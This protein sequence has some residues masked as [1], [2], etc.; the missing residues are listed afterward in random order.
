MNDILDE[1]YW[2][3]YHPSPQANLHK[4]I[5]SAHWQLIERLDKQERKLILRIYRYQRHDC[6]N[7][8]SGE[9]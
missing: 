8:R 1:L 5:E 6:G 2:R 4:E 3:F 7:R 9:F